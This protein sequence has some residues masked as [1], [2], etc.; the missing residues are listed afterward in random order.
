MLNN[1]NAIIFDMDGL[2][3]DSERIAL[4]TFVD[5]CKEHNFKPNMEV[6]H[7]CIGT[8]ASTT[9]EILLE[10]HGDNFPYEAIAKLWARK[11]REEALHKPV[12]MKEGVLSLLQYLKQEGVRIAVV[13]STRKR[14]ALIKLSNAKILHFFDFVLGGDQVSN[15]KPNPE[16]YLTASQK[17]NEPPTK[18][19]A[20][21]DSDNGVLAAHNAGLTVIQVPDLKEPSVEIEALGHLIVK[22]LVEVE[23]ILRRFNSVSS[24]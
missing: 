10:G 5:S 3:L 11:Y 16:V 7:K 8:N 1:I 6:Y 21:E 12:P 24:S 20:L 9:R 2:L 17:L 23:G 14:N 4:S 22:S 18:C 19:L 15:G 13:T